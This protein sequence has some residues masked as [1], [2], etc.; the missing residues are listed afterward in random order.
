MKAKKFF[1]KEEKINL[2]GGLISEGED[3]SK[4]GS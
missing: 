4:L 2:S 1:M 3:Q